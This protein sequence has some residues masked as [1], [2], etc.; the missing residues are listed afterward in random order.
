MKGSKVYF[1]LKVGA[2]WGVTKWINQNHANKVILTKETSTSSLYHNKVTLNSPRKRPQGPEAHSHQT[3]HCL[4][5][6]LGL[7]ISPERS[8]SEWHWSLYHS[9]WECLWCQSLK[10]SSSVTCLSRTVYLTHQRWPQ[11]ACCW[12][13]S[14]CC[15]REGWWWSP[16]PCLRPSERWTG[17]GRGCTSE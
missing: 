10:V 8:H 6:V 2:P 1:A 5:S 16:P 7:S 4:W 13:G 14:S 3:L 17:A 12:G 11:W 15:S 9:R